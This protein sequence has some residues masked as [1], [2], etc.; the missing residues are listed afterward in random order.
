ME[1]KAKAKEKEVSVSKFVNDMLKECFDDKLPEGHID[2]YFGSIKD[3]S[4]QVPEEL[5]WSLDSKR[6]TL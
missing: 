2:K 1:L 5:P 3:D 6:E 4:F